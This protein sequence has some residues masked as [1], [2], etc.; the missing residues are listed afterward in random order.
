MNGEKL[1]RLR[2]EAGLTQTVLADLV[3]VS[4]RTIISWELD[5]RIPASDKIPKLAAA[6]HVTADELLKGE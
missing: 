6:L 2:K 5:E 1:K 4:R 3:D